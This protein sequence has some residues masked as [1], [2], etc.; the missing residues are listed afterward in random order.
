VKVACS[1]E[2][3]SSGYS[4]QIAKVTHQ[5]NEILTGRQEHPSRRGEAGR[6]CATVSRREM[7]GGGGGPTGNKKRGSE[8][9]IRPSDMLVGGPLTKGRIG[10]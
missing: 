10:R 6:S 3:R 4:G 1:E 8:K 5:K 2:S 7:I 9:K